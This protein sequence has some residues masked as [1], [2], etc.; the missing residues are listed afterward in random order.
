MFDLSVLEGF[1]REVRLT[2]PK[3]EAR[4]VTEPITNSTT[5]GGSLLKS[6]S[7]PPTVSS[8]TDTESACVHTDTVGTVRGLDDRIGKW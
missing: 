5:S 2:A 8:A 6:A 3:A 4:I 1:L 7:I